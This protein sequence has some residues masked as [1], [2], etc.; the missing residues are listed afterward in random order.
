MPAVAVVPPVAVV[1]AAVVPP[2][3]VVAVVG[4][5]VV[6]VTVVTV[7]GAAVVCVTVVTVV[8]DA[9][10]CVTVVTVVDDDDD[11]DAVV[12]ANVDVPCSSNVIVINVADTGFDSV[13]PLVVV[14]PANKNTRCFN[15]KFP[16]LMRALARAVL[17]DAEGLS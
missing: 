4:A 14:I 13:S 17:Y 16:Q 12:A 15:T 10:V 8:G 6:C 11:G 2:V 7:V 3:T 9:V 5:A 1:G